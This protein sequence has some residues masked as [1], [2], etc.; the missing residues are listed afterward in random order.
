[1]GKDVIG[2][3][4]VYQ[5]SCQS[6]EEPNQKPEHFSLNGQINDTTFPYKDHVVLYPYMTMVTTTLL[7][8]ST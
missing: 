4:N 5:T 1:M 2:N 8:Y 7:Q 3:G 6:W